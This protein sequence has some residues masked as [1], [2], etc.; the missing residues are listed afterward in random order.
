M[1]PAQHR[2]YRACTAVFD[3]LRA[4][5]HSTYCTRSAVDIL[6]AARHDIDCTCTTVYS[7][8]AIFGQHSAYR[9]CTA[10]VD[11][12][13]AGRHSAYRTIAAAG[14]S[15]TAAVH[16]NYRTA[17][18]A[19][20]SQTAAVHINYRTAAAVDILIA[21]RHSAD[22]ASTAAADILLTA[23]HRTDRAALPSSYSLT[24]TIHHIGYAGVTVI[25]SRFGPGKYCSVH[26]VCQLGQHGVVQRLGLAAQRLRHNTHLLLCRRQYCQRG[27]SVD[28]V[29]AHDY[30]CQELLGLLFAADTLTRFCF[31]I[32][33]HKLPPQLYTRNVLPGH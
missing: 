22:R 24:I 9:A 1:C 20:D 29:H 2:T 7:L 19:G 33:R 8:I 25:I 17:A 6:R 5:R 10:V 11:L 21:A 15:Q 13:P 16:I 31:R 26:H 28:Q 23:R 12:L 27:N 3:S 30:R 32:Q 14:D 4:A 18:A